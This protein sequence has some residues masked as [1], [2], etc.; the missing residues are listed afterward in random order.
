[1][2]PTCPPRRQAAQV[3]VAL[4]DGGNGPEGFARGNFNR[5]DL[6]VILDFYHPTGRLEAL[7]KAACP[8]HEE[9]SAAP[10]RRWCSLLKEEGGAVPP[11]APREWAFGPRRSPALRA[12]LADVEEHFGKNLHRM[13]PPGALWRRAGTSAAGWWR[14]PARPWWAGA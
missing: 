10:A 9:A 11:A 4:T 7:A 14:A 3:L 13:E 8:K 2:R 1:M 5:A 6:V 12:R